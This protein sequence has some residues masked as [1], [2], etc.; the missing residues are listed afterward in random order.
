[1]V[2]KENIDRCNNLGTPQMIELTT[3][4]LFGTRAEAWYVSWSGDDGWK[5]AAVVVAE[6]LAEALSKARKLGIDPGGDPLGIGIPSL[7]DLPEGHPTDVLMSR[8]E[9]EQY[10]ELVRI[11]RAD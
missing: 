2:F 1:M 10:G 4:D 8:E 6:R 7:S 3:D 11:T 9:L 5:G